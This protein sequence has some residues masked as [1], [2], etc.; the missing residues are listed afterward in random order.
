MSFAEASFTHTLEFHIAA[1]DLPSLQL[2]TLTQRLNPSPAAQTSGRCTS[3]PGWAGSRA[4][5]ADA[6]T[7]RRPAA[8]AA[9]RPPG[10]VRPPQGRIL[11]RS[12]WTTAGASGIGLLRTVGRELRC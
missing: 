11:P 3:W 8:G 10:S 9:R 2:W 1:L 4:T 7:A 6:G 5:P 12:G